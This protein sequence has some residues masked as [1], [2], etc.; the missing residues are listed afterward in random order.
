MNKL[1]ILIGIAVI[2]FLG[3]MV[4]NQQQQIDELSDSINQNAENIDKKENEIYIDLELD[5]DYST[6]PEPEERYGIDTPYEDGQLD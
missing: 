3:V 2:I 1:F 6:F 4:F 5:K